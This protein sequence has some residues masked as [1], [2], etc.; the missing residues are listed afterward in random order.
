MTKTFFVIM[1]FAEHY[2]QVYEHGIAP[3]V[4][5][6]GYRCVRADDPYAP[7]N[8]VKNIIENLFYSDIIIADI[9]D[10]NPNVFYELGIAH[11]FGNKTILIC[12]E[13]F[14]KPPFDL[15]NYHIIFY[16]ND[17]DGIRN[18][19]K[20]NLISTISSYEDW[21]KEPNNPVQDFLPKVDLFKTTFY[22][23]Y[24][25]GMDIGYGNAVRLK[26]DEKVYRAIANKSDEGAVVGI[27][28]ENA[29]A[30]FPCK[31]QKT[32]I[33]KYENQIFTPGERVFLRNDEHGINISKQWLKG[34]NETEDVHQEIGIGNS[35][36]SIEIKIGTP[37][38]FT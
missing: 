8:I 28:I 24:N 35:S 1:P 16:K 15:S 29:R 6:F 7:R 34:K 37:V 9:S 27:V 4:N 17:I 22:K 13:K 20:E 3:A 11:C 19:L 23:I 38:I 10:F 5:S 2:R 32:D 31:V 12:D 30:G 26:S 36:N 18:I 14:D 25:A 21:I 33:V